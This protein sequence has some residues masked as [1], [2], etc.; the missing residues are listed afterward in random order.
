MLVHL[1]KVDLAYLAMERGLFAAEQSDDVL[2]KSA[3]TGWLSWVLLHQAG[4]SGD[5]KYIA[6]R[7]ADSIEPRM[8]GARP[9]EVSVWGSLLIS[10]AVAAARDNDAG[11]ADDLINL[12]EVAA[13][14]LDGMGYSPRM[15]NQSPFG[16]PLLIMQT[17]DIAVVTGRPGRALTVAEKMPPNDM[18]LASTARHLADKAFAYTELG[19]VRQAEE[20]LYA[21]RR[22]ASNWMR[23]QSYPRV[24]VAELWEREKRARSAGLRELAEW[25][26]VPL[27]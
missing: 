15:Y 19:K 2:R 27:N 22:Q 7:E 12:A 11:E 10:A 4:S 6:V 26:R 14:R 13:T 3:L 9:E 18:P 23:Y 17:V 21:I 5:A 24:I 8:K 16:L 20:M 25:L 1:G